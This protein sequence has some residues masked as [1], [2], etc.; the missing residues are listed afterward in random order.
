MRRRDESRRRS[1]LMALMARRRTLA[2]PT[3]V[4]S[5][6]GLHSGKPSTVCVRPAPSGVGLVF[7]ASGSGQEIPARAQNV[8]DTSRCTQLGVD[9][10][11]IQTVEH[12]L[13]ALAGCGIDDAYIE[14]SG[15]ELPAMDG[16]A[17]P[18]VHALRSAG[19]VAQESG[20]V[21]PVRVE[22]P[23]L[24][25]EGGSTIL[26]EPAASFKATV[27]LDYPK[28]PYIGVQVVRFDS[29][30]MSYDEQ[31]A[32]S[33]TYGFLH[34]VEALRAH[35]LALGASAENALVLGDDD[36]VGERRF[37]DEMA[38]HK[39]LDL[40]GDLALVGR[41]V[42]AEITAIK[43]GHAVNTSLARALSS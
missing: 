4:I 42:L 18:F 37:E 25:T 20:S 23:R 6:V 22:R 35:G 10:V 32:P 12:V 43:P 19:V 9:G 38:R 15:D 14:T 13:S 21:D 40:I 27:V 30:R 1:A 33:R 29:S 34:E 24:F 26:L 7:V 3:D 39:L 17:L 36:Y 2:R 28:H 16:S 8:V 11:V 41:P 5:G 31:I